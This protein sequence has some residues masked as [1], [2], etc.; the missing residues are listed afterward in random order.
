MLLNNFSAKVFDE[1]LHPT[2]AVTRAFLWCGARAHSIMYSLRLCG[3]EPVACGS[4]LVAGLQFAVRNLSWKD[5]Y[6]QIG[7]FL[8]KLESV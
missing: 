4:V 1:R 8:K 5:L 7:G 6:P 3:F 2:C